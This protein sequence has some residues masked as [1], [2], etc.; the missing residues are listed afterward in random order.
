MVEQNT[1]DKFFSRDE[2]VRA[3]IS[4]EKAI[5]L[6][7]DVYNAQHDPNCGSDGCFDTWDQLL[8]CESVAKSTP[9]KKFPNEENKEKRENNENVDVSGMMND[10]C[11][12][13]VNFEL[14]ESKLQVIENLKNCNYLTYPKEVA[15]FLEEFFKEYDSKPGHWIYISQ[16]W[17]PRAINR[18]FSA[19]IKFHESG[20]KTIQNWAAY[21]VFL[22]KKRK[23]RRNL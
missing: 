17:N 20:R 22:I 9:V 2:E 13:K 6:I 18:T 4:K 15:T 21:F 12:R 3:T 1:H 7:E 16:H 5:R 19:L 14:T 11:K 23:P 8:T 10:G